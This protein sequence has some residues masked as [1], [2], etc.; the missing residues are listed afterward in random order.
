MSGFSDVFTLRERILIEGIMPERALLRLKRAEIDLF[1]VQKPR[2]NQILF[3]VNRKDSEKVFAIYPNVCYNKGVYSAYTAKK[4]GAVGLAAHIERLKKRLGLVFGAALFAIALFVSDGLVLGI[5]CIGTDVYAREARAALWENGVRTFAP[6]RADKADAICARLIALGDVEYCSVKKKGFY[7]QVEMRLSPFAKNT[8]L[9]GDMQA[10]HTGTVVGITVLRGTPT[11]KIGDEV[12]Q[13]DTL[14]EGC[15]YT[16]DGGQVRVE[17]IAKAAIACVYESEIAATEEQEAFAKAY[18]HL[19]I[20]DGDKI[21][22]KTITQ[23]SEHTFCVAIE[24][25]AIETFNL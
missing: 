20:S 23:T 12:R 9:Q 25:T 3:S 1:D 2:K 21:T 24:Y 14:V 11:K 15:F 16:Q 6:Y 19:Q 4:M 13:G 8:F 7:V 5:Q 10:K 18:L 17:A 22:K